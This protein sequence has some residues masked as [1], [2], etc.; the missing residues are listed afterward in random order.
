MR[1]FLSLSALVF[2]FVSCSDDD[3][4]TE[5]PIMEMSYAHLVTTSNTSGMLCVSVKK[6][7]HLKKR[8]KKT[9]YLHLKIKL[10]L[11]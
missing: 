8:L 7:S 9:V 4:S 1:K 3:N 10:N 6:T 5:E 11:S 2:L